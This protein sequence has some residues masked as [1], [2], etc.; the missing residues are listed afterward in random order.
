[1]AEADYLLLPGHCA[2]DFGMST[3]SASISIA[4]IAKPNLFLLRKGHFCR[5]VRGGWVSVIKRPELDTA[6]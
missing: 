6:G 1:M 2:A 4:T 3:S 5:G